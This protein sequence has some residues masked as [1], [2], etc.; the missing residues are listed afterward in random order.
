MRNNQRFYRW[1]SLLLVLTMIA[2]LLPMNVFA[3]ESETIM[4][5]VETINVPR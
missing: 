2:A 4:G 3:D 5:K 1:T